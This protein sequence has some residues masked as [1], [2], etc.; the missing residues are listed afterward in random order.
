MPYF[1]NIEEGLQISEL[2]FLHEKLDV[3]DSAH[4]DYNQQSL[5]TNDQ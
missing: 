2:S 5:I 3:S 4:M 1:E